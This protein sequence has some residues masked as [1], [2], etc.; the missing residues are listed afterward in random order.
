MPFNEQRTISTD[1]KLKLEVES[2]RYQ[3]STRA[4]IVGA[5]FPSAI[6]LTTAIVAVIGIVVSIAT[7]RQQVAHTIADD[8][9]KALQQAL[10]MATDP[11]GGPE[12]HISGIYQLGQFWTLDQAFEI[13]APTL[14]AI[15]TLPGKPNPDA[16]HADVSSSLERC[17]AVEAIGAAF[18]AGVLETSQ[19]R[20]AA[21]LLGNVSKKVPGLIPA[22]NVAFYHGFRLTTTGFPEA[23]DL[24][25]TTPQLFENE[26]CATPLGATRAALKKIAEHLVDADLSNTDLRSLDLS[27]TDLRGISFEHADVV[28][29]NM[30]CANLAGAD[31]TKATM[32]DAQQPSRKA[33]MELANIRDVKGLD[34]DVT[35]TSIS[36]TDEEWNEWRKAQ[37]DGA[38]LEKALK[39]SLTDEQKA[40]IK[41]ACFSDLPSP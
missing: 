20:I 21:M 39:R 25:P 4:R 3:N 5:L 6:S 37:F 14:T 18:R 19:K 40:A 28:F 8:E 32:K 27:R 9:S 34:P 26:N 23:E 36:I 11:A 22:R 31:F 35:K 33:W 13:V 12:R 38:V 30:R 7:Y 17:A 10:S 2:L 41:T 1:E 16:K 29:T 24:V 15:L